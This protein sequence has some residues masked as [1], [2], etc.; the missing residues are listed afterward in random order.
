V[1][2]ALAPRADRRH[3]RLWLALGGTSAVALSLALA[4]FP[5]CLFGVGL[6]VVATAIVHTDLREFRIPDVANLAS[7]LLGLAACALDASSAWDVAAVVARAAIM[8][9]ALFAFRALYRFARG[10]DGL[11]LG[12]VKLAGVAGLWLDA[13]RLPVCWELACASALGWLLWRRWT[14]GAPIA[15]VD[16]LAFGAFLAP[17]IWAVWLWQAATR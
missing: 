7:A 11:G 14:T 16:R 6:A 8:F 13:E 12:D 5:G 10:R 4:P 3:G 1:T 15:A 17:A 2:A 9:G